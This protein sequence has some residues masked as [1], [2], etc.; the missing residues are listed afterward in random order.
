MDS[1]LLR[2]AVGIT[3][4]CAARTP[5]RSRLLGFWAARGDNAVRQ[6]FV[7]CIIFGCD[8][9]H[10][11][12]VGWGASDLVEVEEESNVEELRKVQPNMY[13]FSSSLA[14]TAYCVLVTVR[15]MTS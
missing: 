15:S 4:P 6:T 13:H 1:C 11:L 9:S 2:S 10:H 7:F 14:F 5:N 12:S 3:P 8:P